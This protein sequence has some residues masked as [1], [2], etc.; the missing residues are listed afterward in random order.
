[1]VAFDLDGFMQV[2]AERDRAADDS[3]MK[4][5]TRTLESKLDEYVGGTLGRYSG[6]EAL[7]GLQGAT[8]DTA[9]VLAA[10]GSLQAVGGAPSDGRS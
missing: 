5:A 7:V 6:D 1:M 3:L 10:R 8:S 9:F 2:N 4:R